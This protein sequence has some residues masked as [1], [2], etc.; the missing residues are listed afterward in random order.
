M[1]PD[2]SAKNVHGNLKKVMITW[3]T[4]RYPERDFSGL[5]NGTGMECYNMNVF[6]T[7]ATLS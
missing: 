4:I 6:P 5:V 7:Q 3:N 1:V 2:R